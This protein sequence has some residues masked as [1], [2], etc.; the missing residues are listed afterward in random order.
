MFYNTIKSHSAQL[1]H[2]TFWRKSYKIFLIDKEEF[3]EDFHIYEEE[4]S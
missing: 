2:L 4:F 3:K 1:I